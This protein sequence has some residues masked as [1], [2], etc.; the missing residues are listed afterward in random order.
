MV[1]SN[2]RACLGK[3]P[4][5]SASLSL[6]NR[7][8]RNRTFGGVG[9]ERNKLLIPLGYPIMSLYSYLRDSLV[10]SISAFIP[11]VLI[12]SIVTGL[13][14]FAIDSSTSS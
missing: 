3:E 5:D 4:L 12:S 9:T 2:F 11:S 8:M 1:F 7:R 6:L 10:K 14:E 13:D